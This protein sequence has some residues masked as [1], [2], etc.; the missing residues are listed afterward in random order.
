M[1]SLCRLKAGSQKYL[2]YPDMKDQ[3]TD[4][5]SSNRFAD[6]FWPFGVS[7][8]SGCFGLYVF[9]LGLFF[10]DAP[11]APWHGL[12]FIV[13]AWSGALVAIQDPNR[14]KKA[15]NITLLAVLL[16]GLLAAIA[17][18]FDDFSWDGMAVRIENVL[19]LS[20]GWNP[21]KDPGFEQRSHF[22]K[23]NPYLLGGTLTGTHY[24][25]GTILAAYLVNLTGNL[26]AGKAV[27]PILMLVSLGV[28]FGAFRAVGLRP[29]WSLGLALCVMLN[30]VSIY[31]SSSYYID[32][33]IGSLYASLVCSGLRLLF[34]PL[35][36]DGVVALGLS[37]LALS[38][39]KTSGLFYGI[40]A[41]VAFLGFFAILKIRH[42]RE[43]LIFVLTAVFLIWPAGWAVRNIA[44]LQR[45]SWS[46]L[47]NSINI[48]SPYYGVGESSLAAKEFLNNSKW[49]IFF[50]SHLAP[51]EVIAEAV[52][53]KFPFWLNRRE[54]ALFEDLSPDP[55]AGGF[56]PLYGAFLILAGISGGLL[57]YQPRP[58]LGAWFPIF[59][60]LIGVM[61]SQ[62][63][64]ARWVPQAWLIPIF[65]LLPL[66]AGTGGLSGWRKTLP[67]LAVAAGVLN[68]L[69][70]L[71]FY[72][73]GCFRV[74]SV[75]DS[76]LSFLKSL[77]AP[78]S[79]YMPRLSSNR[80]WLIR[81]NIPFQLISQPPPKP[82]LRFPRTNTDVGL[83]PDWA[84][85]LGRPALAAEWKRRGLVLESP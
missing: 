55:R 21:I 11:I 73:V 41:N 61:L 46:Y 54:L 30:P 53:T 20:S 33:Q 39:A 1:F 75:L 59:P 19:A 14:L 56:G 5:N 23:N 4:G 74:Q 78:L 47:S 85:R 26:N 49:E 18:Q 44:G 6:Y 24:T 63:W 42:S 10:M 67:A 58:P 80:V 16:C 64:W 38:A 43:R 35:R 13:F 3:M 71:L 45:P 70:I 25:F 79:V 60:T 72:S 37:F 8:L 77:P 81:E 12:A 69:L 57:W 82:H 32:G 50:L 65:L 27:T 22:L 52:K 7:L 48:A 83:P 9:T 29:R 68:S 17:A 2:E 62:T 66:L 36:A 34:T 51:T 76:Q 15:N 40:I 31:Q 28:S 84:Q